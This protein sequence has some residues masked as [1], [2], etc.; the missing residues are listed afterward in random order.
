MYL[1]PDDK[2]RAVEDLAQILLA[3]RSGFVKQRQ[4]RRH[5][6]PLIVGYLARV[7]SAGLCLNG[8]SIR[9]LEVDYRL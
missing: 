5:D 8:T 1:R 7:V 6:V 9:T 2:V 3:L 4:I